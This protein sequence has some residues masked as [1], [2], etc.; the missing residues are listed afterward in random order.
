MAVTAATWASASFPAA[1][2]VWVWPAPRR[3]HHLRRRNPPQHPHHYHHLLQQ[4][5]RA[6]AVGARTATR[7]RLPA[8]QCHGPTWR[9]WRP[10]PPHQRRQA[11]ASREWTAWHRCVARR[12]TWAAATTAP[13]LPW[14]APVRSCRHA[15]PRVARAAVAPPALLPLTTCGLAA[16]LPCQTAERGQTACGLPQRQTPCARQLPPPPPCWH[17]P[18]TPAVPPPAP[19]R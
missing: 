9:Q 1:A 11:P 8:S 13:P 6:A 4:P 10:V 19:Q 7:W 17:P 15:A 5:A 16:G 14:T 18:P 12:P 2:T 3:Q